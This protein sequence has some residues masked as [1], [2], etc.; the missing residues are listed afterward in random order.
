[1]PRCAR[2]RRYREPPTEY[3][4]VAGRCPSLDPGLAATFFDWIPAFPVTRDQLTM[5]GEGNVAA[6]RDLKELIGREPI[7]FTNETISYLREHDA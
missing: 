6:P 1:M 3:P 4:D 2:C 5:L 7:S